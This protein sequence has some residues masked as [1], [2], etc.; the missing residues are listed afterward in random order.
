M[1]TLPAIELFPVPLTTK[2]C[3][4]VTKPALSILILSLTLV[5][6]DGVVPNRI[7]PGELVS[8]KAPSA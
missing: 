8:E 4:I 2:F 3:A 1:P 7:R 6:P 5:E